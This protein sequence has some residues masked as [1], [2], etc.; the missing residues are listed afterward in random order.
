MSILSDVTGTDED[1]RKGST[2]KG[3]GSCSGLLGHKVKNLM[4]VI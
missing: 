2:P 3:S 1:K 4:T